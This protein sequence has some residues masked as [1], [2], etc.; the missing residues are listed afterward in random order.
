MQ[1]MSMRALWHQDQRKRSHDR[2]RAEALWRK[3]LGCTDMTLEELVKRSSSL[4]RSASRPE[5]WRRALPFDPVKVASGDQKKRFPI[6]HTVRVRIAEAMAF[7]AHTRCRTALFSMLAK[8]FASLAAVG[9]R[10]HRLTTG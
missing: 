5:L 6:G 9:Q 4:G 2:H 10:L 8:F 3:Q 1:T 7:A